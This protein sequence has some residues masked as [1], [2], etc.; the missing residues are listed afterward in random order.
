MWRCR[1]SLLTGLAVAAILASNPAFAE[2]LKFMADMKGW[3]E[4]PP[5]DSA[6]TGVGDV[7]VDTAAKRLTW[8]VTTSNLSGEPVAAHFHGP[9][10]PGKNADPVIDISDSL[11]SGSADITDEQLADL[12]AGKWYLNVHTDKFPDGEIRGQVEKVQ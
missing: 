7:T 11:A 2:T 9:A 10:D 4:V 6:A 8:T 1:N 12:Q 5:N 3:S